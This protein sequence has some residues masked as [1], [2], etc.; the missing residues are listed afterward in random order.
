MRVCLSGGLTWCS[1]F[2]FRSLRGAKRRSNPDFLRDAGLLRCAR[3]DE[4][5]LVIISRHAERA[6]DVV[7]A[8]GKLHAG[9]GRMLADSR[10]IDFL[11]G[12]LALRMGEATFGLQI[13]APLLQ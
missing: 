5:C 4:L 7:V 6:G 8:R 13:G 1:P 9:A 10:A 3:N 2:D 12:R 11:P